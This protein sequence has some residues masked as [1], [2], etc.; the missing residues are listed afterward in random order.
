[1]KKVFGVIAV[2][3][4][5]G[6]ALAAS[7]VKPSREHPGS[8]PIAVTPQ[9]VCIGSDDNYYPAGLNW[10]VKYIQSKTNPTETVPVA[11]TFDGKTAT[12]SFYMNTCNSE[13]YDMVDTTNSNQSGGAAALAIRKSLRDA[14][15]HGCDIGNHTKHHMSGAD[16]KLA[17]WNVEIDSAL[18]DLTTMGFA[19]NTIYGFRTPYLLYNDSTF[20]VLDQFSNFKYDCSIESGLDSATNAK[21]FVW[22][23]TLD[24]GVFE[25]DT[26]STPY[27]DENETIK[28]VVGN[29][30]GLWEAPA[31]CIIVPPELRHQIWLQRIDSVDVKVFQRDADGNV[32]FDTNDNPIVLDTVKDSIFMVDFD[33]TTGKITGL[34][35]NMWS[36]PANG[37]LQMD[38]A[39]FLAVMKYTLDERL[40]GNRAPFCFGMHSNIFY[41]VNGY[42][43]EAAQEY[44]S[45]VSP[46]NATVP[47]MRGAMEAFINYAI[48]KE[49]VRVVSQKELVDWCKT[50]VPFS[51]SIAIVN[52]ASSLGWMNFHVRT[53]AGRIS[54]TGLPSGEKTSVSLYTVSGRQVASTV[55]NGTSLNWKIDNL[56]AGTYVIKT[57][58]KGFERVSNVVVK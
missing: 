13:W 40:A 54:V 52:K 21:N 8:F 46:P 1:M 55:V 50:P 4:L 44:G 43:D 41:D 24:N 32:V 51:E 17:Y 58:V 18:I 23:Y 20:K 56:A 34:D 9:F 31:Y 35:Y 33:T 49:A 30:P 29:H 27:M 39:Q 14:V 25:G 45:M 2:L 16:S 48:S 7:N 42:N 37:G 11:G 10:I 26:G 3:F 47:K 36:S 38:S 15:A 28:V 22:P 57:K 5:I 12:M 6:S 19:A 53:I